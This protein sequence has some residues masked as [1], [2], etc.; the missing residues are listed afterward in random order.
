MGEVK[1]DNHDFRRILKGV[2]AWPKSG[3]RIDLANISP[4]K[5]KE[6]FLSDLQIVCFQL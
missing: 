3:R 5:K 2:V 4:K 1:F 6:M